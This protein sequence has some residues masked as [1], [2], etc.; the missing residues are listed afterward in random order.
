VLGCHTVATGE[1][2]TRFRT[3]TAL[4]ISPQES[5]GHMGYSTLNILQ[6]VCVC[7]PVDTA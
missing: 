2:L 7:L 5:H 4:L 3:T 6:D 1:V